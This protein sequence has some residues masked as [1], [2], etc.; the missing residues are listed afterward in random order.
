M[1]NTMGIQKVLSLSILD[2]KFF[3]VYISVKVTY[4]AYSCK[5]IVEVT[6]L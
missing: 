3:I 4:L 6:S 5:Q 2:K 1:Q